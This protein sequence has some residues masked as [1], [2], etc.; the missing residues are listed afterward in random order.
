MNK[1]FVPHDIHV[2]HEIEWQALRQGS[3]APDDLEWI[4]MATSLNSP[5][6]ADAG[7]S[8]GDRRAQPTCG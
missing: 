8:A 5:W 2:K 1:T 6:N 3:Q 4:E 7:Q